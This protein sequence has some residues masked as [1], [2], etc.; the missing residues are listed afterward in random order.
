MQSTPGGKPTSISLI[1]LPIKGGKVTTENLAPI[2]AFEINLV[3]PGDLKHAHFISGAGTITYSATNFLTPLPSLPAC[4]ANNTT[5]GETSN[6]VYGPLLVGPS[7]LSVQQ[8]SID[9][10]LQ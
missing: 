4:V 2:V 1:G 8:F 3:G 7:N 9:P 10:K 5:T 6:S